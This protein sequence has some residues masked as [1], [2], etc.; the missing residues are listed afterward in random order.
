[1]NKAYEHIPQEKFEFAQLN[2]TLHDEKLETKSR[3]YFADAMLRFSKNKSSVIAAYIIGFLLLF[4]LIVPIFS[5][6]SVYDKDKTYINF[7]PYVE[8]IAQMNLG[9][10]DGATTL[11]SQNERQ[12]AA[13][14]AIGV[15][16]GYNPI[17]KVLS[18]TST[19]ERE[20]GKEVVKT[21]R[22]LEINRYYLVGIVKRNI[23]YEEFDK[24]QQFQ[25]ETGLQ[26]LYPMVLTEDIYGKKVTFD[27]PP[28]D[29]IWYKC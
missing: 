15:E 8:S 18:E 2:A 7:P 27:I 29:N 16:T 20:R 4:S 1:M 11:S 12:V 3:S 19:V 13:M 9:I 6:Y 21:T 23:S 5:P 14:E 22:A 28:S 24:I 26:V 10:L 17:I 25:N